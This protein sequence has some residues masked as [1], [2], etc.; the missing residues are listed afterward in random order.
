M[1]NRL[2]CLIFEAEWFHSLKRRCLMGTRFD[3]MAATLGTAIVL[4]PSARAANIV[5]NPGF[6]A[7]NA[8]AGPVTPPTDWTVTA[9]GGIADAGVEEGFANSGNNAAYIGYG[10]LSQAL[11]TVVGTTYTVSFYVGIDDFTTLNDSN[12]TFDATASGTNLGTVD[13]FGGTLR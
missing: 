9:I 2:V 10:T 8:S 13:L 6:E 1:Q 3:V 4:A 11:N 12:A 5:Q 7:D